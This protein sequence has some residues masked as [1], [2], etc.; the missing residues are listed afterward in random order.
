MPN[1]FLFSLAMGA[2]GTAS[3]FQ[4]EPHVK[5]PSAWKEVEHTRDSLGSKQIELTFAVKLNNKNELHD[6]LMAVS[7]PKSPEYGKLLSLEQVNALTNPAPA[8][9]DKIKIYLSSFGVNN[10]EVK[11]GF[12]RAVVRLDTAEKMLGAKYAQYRHEGSGK[13]ALRCPE[14][15]YNLP[16]DVAQ[17]VDFVAPTVSFP[18][19]QMN[20]RP[21]FAQQIQEELEGLLDRNTPDSLRALY[22]VND[23]MGGA[24]DARQACTAFLG[25]Y[26]L[27]SDL[28]SFYDTYFP[29]LSGVPMAAVVGPDDGKA[30]VEASLDAE[31]MTV[32]GAG[33]PTEFWSFD[34]R[35]PGAPENEPFLD[36]LYLLGNTT[37]PPLVFSTSY[38]ED[39]TSVSFDYAERMNDEFQRQ[40]LRGISFIFA[41]GDSGVGAMAGKCDEFMAM[42]PSGSPYVTAVGATTKTGPEIGAELSSGGFSNLW[43]RPSWQNEAVEKY[44]S[45]ASNMPDAW[46]YNSTGRGFPDVSAQGTGYVVINGGITLPAVAGTSASSPT[47][48]GIVALVNDARIAAGKS[49]LGFLNPFIYETPEMFNDITS[50]NNP[51]CSTDGFYAA[52]GW[53]PV[54]GNGTPDYLKMLEAALALP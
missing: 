5:I 13:E 2:L 22:N 29:E 37:N 50:G 17:L 51:G 14:S 53:D 24:S 25:Q 35:Q 42:Y 6:T 3:A 10:V 4:L 8:S 46:R 40:A 41:S 18:P 32:M 45:T 23:V 47:F 11:A 1:L 12:V 28:Q 19:T 26:Y 48:G 49:P 52:A 44:L 16:D 34:G 9:I 39:E 43:A 36:W 38:G 7:S 30:G 33:V 27:E 21:E 20:V 31:Y 15:G 54:T